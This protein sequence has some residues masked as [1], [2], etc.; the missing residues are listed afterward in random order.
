MKWIQPDKS[1]PC[2]R[3]RPVDQIAK[4]AKVPAAP[5]TPRAHAI[6]ADGHPSRA[7]VF[8]L[9][10]SVRR[11]DKARMRSGLAEGCNRDVVISQAESLGQR[12]AIVSGS[13]GQVK[14]RSVLGADFDFDRRPRIDLQ[15]AR[16]R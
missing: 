9:P 3:S 2:L 11:N 13:R 16:T 5:V 7:Q 10:G 8:G 12:N 15:L 6:E 4:I 1:G 14:A